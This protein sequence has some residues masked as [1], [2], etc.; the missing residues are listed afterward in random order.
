MGQASQPEASNSQGEG[1]A[2]FLEAKEQDKADEGLLKRGRKP[3]LQE[4]QP[5]D[6]WKKQSVGR[7]GHHHHYGGVAWSPSPLAARGSGMVCLWI[8]CQELLYKRGCTT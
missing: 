8:F 7:C 5:A 1:E 6:V 3:E 4:E 2:A